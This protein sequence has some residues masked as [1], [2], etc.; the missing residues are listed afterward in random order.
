[1]SNSVLIQGIADDNH[2]S[3]IKHLLALPNP[4]CITIAVAFLTA[5]GL[6]G[7][8][9][10][11]AQVSSRT[12][13]FVGIRNGI[14][15]AQGLS[16]LLQLS[17]SIYAVDTG[18][19]SLLFHPKIYAARSPQEAR[20]IVGSAN[21]TRG[22]L[23]SNIEASLCL[24][25]PLYDSANATFVADLESQLYGM[26]SE[27]P[28]HV[29]SISDDPTIQ[30]LLDSGRLVDEDTVVPP[31][32]TSSVHQSDPPRVMP[33]KTS[34]THSTVGPRSI[35]A[36]NRSTS[37]PSSISP[38]SQLIWQSGPL[39]RRA[40]NIPDGPATN[41]TGSMFFTK[42]PMGNIDQRHYF[43]DEVFKHL[44]WRRDPSTPHYERATAQFQIVI[45]GVD[46][47]TF[48]L[49]LSHNTRTDSAAYIQSNSMTQ[50]H[51]HN[52]RPL[53]AHE[54]LLDRTMYLYK[55]ARQ[56]ILEID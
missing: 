20:L 35:S 27:Y 5:R 2:E 41:A 52:A 26:I 37:I 11:I 56:F 47:G 17:C 38:P 19:R 3:A 30:M 49:A 39:S 7:I 22:G 21:L 29:T 9:Q 13:V 14:T 34:F 24:T 16:S 44:D 48:E 43:R 53:V 10:A 40:L 50:V 23:L 8:R 4:Q 18:S 33:L 6:S 31:T 12:T 51:W 15:S 42:G 32:P 36:A 55:T 28:D 54:N 1:M 46:Y 25:L 45:A